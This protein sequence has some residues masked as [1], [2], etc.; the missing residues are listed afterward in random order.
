MRSP[1]RSDE[2]RRFLTALFSAVAVNAGEHGVREAWIQ[3]FPNLH[4]T[5]ILSDNA[6][7]VAVL[8]DTHPSALA[9][10]IKPNGTIVAEA[11]APMERIAVAAADESGRIY[12]AAE[13]SWPSDQIIHTAVFRPMSGGV[14]SSFD[15]DVSW[16]HNPPD[17]YYRPE[18]KGVAAAGHNT[19]YFVG[20]W[21]PSNGS[22]H[23]I[24]LAKVTHGVKT[25]FTSYQSGPDFS[26]DFAVSVVNSGND[27]YAVG[28]AG[29]LRYPDI[30]VVKY[31]VAGQQFW[32]LGSKPC[33]CTEVPVAAAADSS[34][35]L[36]VFGTHRD[37]L[38]YEFPLGPPGYIVMKIDP[39]GVILWRKLFGTGQ[40]RAI[41]LDRHDAIIVTGTAGTVKY[42]T[43]GQL[44]WSVNDDGAAMQLVSGEDIVL[45]DSIFREDGLHDV[46]TTKL[47][48]DGTRLWQARY[49]DAGGGDNLLTGI[50][51]DDHD[52]VYVGIRLNGGADG[53][54]VKYVE[55][56]PRPKPTPTKRP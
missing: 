10:L 50:A 22:D 8:G 48:S 14:E 13:G 4:L 19:A 6:G 40:A 21:N 41:A 5:Q 7:H 38:S 34:G 15:L 31:S 44:L 36:V 46:Q 16:P 3:R 30:A 25:W 1:R 52:D 39:Q 53:A 33:F 49:H 28:T 12:V 18:V 35:N 56:G 42:G 43:D 23:D 47:L 45:G 55:K 20:T 24:F 32:A 26:L 9:F 54:A 27:V 51:A 37:L 17:A 11:R 29:S 2:C